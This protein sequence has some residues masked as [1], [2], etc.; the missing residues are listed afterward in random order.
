MS[1]SVSNMIALHSKAQE[2]S[3]AR[4]LEYQEAMATQA[5]HDRLKYNGE[6]ADWGAVPVYIDDSSYYNPVH[7]GHENVPNKNEAGEPLTNKY[8]RHQNFRTYPQTGS[9]KARVR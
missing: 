7:W 1:Y 9:K 6:I 5:N 3:Y 2:D 8:I 4:R